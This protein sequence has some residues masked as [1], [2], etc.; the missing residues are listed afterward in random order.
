MA[1]LS[2]VYA[3]FVVIAAKDKKDAKSDILLKNKK[4][5]SDAR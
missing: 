2:V 1:V 3:P 5:E 4:E